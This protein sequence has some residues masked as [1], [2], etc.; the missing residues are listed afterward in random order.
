MKL[1]AAFLVPALALANLG[2]F[3]FELSMVASG[4]PFRSRYDPSLLTPHG[5]TYTK[6]R[7][8]AS[9]STSS[10]ITSTLISQLACGALKR[11]LKDQTHVSCDLTTNSNA[12]LQ[13]LVGPVTVKGRGWKSRL[14]LT[15][16]AIEATVDTC[17]IDMGRMLANQKLVLTTPG[18]YKANRS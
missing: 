6:S 9:K 11:R 14:G 7:P 18:R 8:P 15:C 2:I 13:G 3:A 16:K 17:Q 5:N 1:F 10:G 4:A 12:L